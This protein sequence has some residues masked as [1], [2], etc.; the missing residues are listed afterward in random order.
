ML[1]SPIHP[2]CI[3]NHTHTLYYNFCARH[4]STCSFEWRPQL[5]WWTPLQAYFVATFTGGLAFLTK[6][7]DG[8]KTVCGDW[9]T[10]AGVTNEDQ[11]EQEIATSWS[12][13]G[14]PNG[15]SLTTYA[16]RAFL[17][18]PVLAPLKPHPTRGNTVP[19]GMQ[20][21]A[22]WVGF[23]RLSYRDAVLRLT[24]GTYD[25]QERPQEHYTRR[26]LG[27]TLNGKGNPLGNTWADAAAANRATDSAAAANRATDSVG[28]F[29]GF[30]FCHSGYTRCSTFYC[31]FPV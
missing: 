20:S 24:P 27:G 10:R 4:G 15:M 8:Y 7:A 25:H 19:S 30:G 1:N 31:V 23:E 3:S 13:W 22:K 11:G 6:P 29:S 26:W 2:L 9:A 12:T 18:L 28:S 5:K 21:D 14:V 17:Q 16:Y